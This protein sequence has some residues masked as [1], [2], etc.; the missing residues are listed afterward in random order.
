M[1]VM[2]N[3]L[4][5]LRNGTLMLIGY[6]LFYGL[7]VLIIWSIGYL[8]D[9]STTE[10]NSSEPAERIE[11][12]QPPAKTFRIGAEC[13]DGWRSSA[14]GSGACSHHGGVRF[15]IYN[16]PWIPTTDN[17][18]SL[19]IWKVERSV[20]GWVME[21]AFSFKFYPIFGISSTVN[22]GTSRFLR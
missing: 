8:L 2:K 14:T 3:A 9:L 18:K 5:S 22:I 11:T 20:N 4:R 6:S 19:H 12:L 17:P 7:V 16:E 10:R 15:W 21:W 1:P 13:M